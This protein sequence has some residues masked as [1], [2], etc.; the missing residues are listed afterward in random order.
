[1]DNALYF[2]A[3]A[4]VA[5]IQMPPLRIVAR[6]GRAGGAIA[7]WLDARHRK[8]ALQNL[9][10][11]FGNEKSPEEIRAIAKENFRRLGENYCSAIKT[12]AMT[13]DEMKRHFVF[14]GAEKILPHE[15]NAGP[16]SRIIAVGH[17]G[18]FELYAH[19]GQFVP[20]FKCA[21]T[22]RSLKQ[23]SLNRLMQSLR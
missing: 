7:F 12:A 2:F 13:P 8:V 22:Y 21:T 4:L 16:Q 9:Q 6:I 15:T 10:M 19:F 1:M 18:N 23:P 20:I 14:T 11:V 17:F 5:F 3:R